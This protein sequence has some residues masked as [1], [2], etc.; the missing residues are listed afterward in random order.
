MTVTK[1]GKAVPFSY[2]AATKKNIP[3][4]KSKVEAW[5]EFAPGFS[6]P[7]K[8][9][10]A[11]PRRSHSP[12]K[13]KTSASD[14]S[15]AKKESAASPSR[16]PTQKEASGSGLSAVKKQSTAAQGGSLAK[17]AASSIKEAEV[18]PKKKKAS[19]FVPIATAAPFVP[20][21]PFMVGRNEGKQPY[22]LAA[23]VDTEPS[24]PSKPSC[25]PVDDV[26]AGPAP[27]VG[28]TVIYSKFECQMEVTKLPQS[29][30]SAGIFPIVS[31]GT[32]SRT[33]LA[34]SHLA[35]PSPLRTSESAASS[36]SS[37]T[38]ASPPYVT[39]LSSPVRTA[40]ISSGSGSVSAAVLASVRL[41][42]ILASA[43]S[44]PPPVLAAT[45]S[46][47]DDDDDDEMPGKPRNNRNKKKRLG[48]GPASSSTNGAQ[49]SAK[50]ADAAA[51]VAPGKGDGGDKS[52]ST[53][54]TGATA[55]AGPSSSVVAS[56]APNNDAVDSL[57]AAVGGLSISPME[58]QQRV[59]EAEREVRLVAKRA[60]VQALVNAHDA[61]HLDL[62]CLRLAADILV[63]SQDATI[64]AHRVILWRESGYFRGEGVLPAESPEGEPQEVV[65]TIDN[66][67]VAHAIQFMY[68]L[69]YAGGQVSGVEDVLTGDYICLHIHR[70][71]CGMMLDVPA[72]MEFAAERLNEAADWF[73]ANS[74]EAIEAVRSLA[75]THH[76][77]LSVKR[78]LQMILSGRRPT[79]ANLQLRE[80]FGGLMRA[81]KPVLWGNDEFTRALL[82]ETEFRALWMTAELNF[83]PL[84]PPE[85]L[86]H[87][88]SVRWQPSS[89]GSSLPAHGR[90][91]G[92]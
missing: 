16:S 55:E 6:P 90:P 89:S 50:S 85:R 24:G 76:L 79:L 47:S 64:P 42:N 74:A 14:A 87:R 80:A 67:F 44:F 57:S 92:A 4:P 66:H 61:G 75:L 25:L 69:K 88:G 13:K 34:A 58:G 62:G 38:S 63:I 73:E 48:P 17:E 27:L 18:P 19:S 60:Y 2:A 72:M 71:V 84:P 49:E 81:M 78:G 45:T 37:A 26:V 54:A 31:I 9:C 35:G 46:T 7:K 86:Q 52:G 68:D 8:Q 39:A 29:S 12:A 41:G 40:D 51:A 22:P 32:N 30:V 11:A 1:A 70:Y 36:T 56:P 3:T 10:A 20:G 15:P 5:P 33:S 23:G 82:S 65:V 83:L 77:F 91:A 28:P 43:P 59:E 53:P 21:Q